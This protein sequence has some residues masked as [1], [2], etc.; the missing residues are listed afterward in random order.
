MTVAPRSCRQAG[1]AGAGSSHPS[2]VAIESAVFLLSHLPP[3]RTTLGGIVVGSITTP[4]TGPVVGRVGPASWHCP[5]MVGLTWKKSATTAV[6][7]K[8]QLAWPK[9]PTIALG[10]VAAVP[11][12]ATTIPGTAPVSPGLVTVTVPFDVNFASS[13]NTVPWVASLLI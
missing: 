2:P 1:T 9:R 4:S 10:C 11:A 6:L 13:F 8:T 12:L 7:S 5:A 3:N